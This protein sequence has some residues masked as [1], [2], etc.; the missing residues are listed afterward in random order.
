[1]NQIMC[2]EINI[3]KVLYKILTTTHLYSK[4]TRS[5]LKSIK[6]EKKTD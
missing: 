1:M 5:L 2:K 4:N 3:N 6:K